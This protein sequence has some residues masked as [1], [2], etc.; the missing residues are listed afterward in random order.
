MIRLYLLLYLLVVFIIDYCDFFRTIPFI[1]K[2]II[3]HPVI[4]HP[5][6][7]SLCATWWMSL[8]FVCFGLNP[9]FLILPFF[10]SIVSRVI[11]VV[12]KF[13]N[14]VLDYIYF[15]L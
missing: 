4:C 8:M 10:S 5:L 11:E 13:L 14:N 15:R 3:K 6:V 9:W 7:C 12:M 1:S 2:M